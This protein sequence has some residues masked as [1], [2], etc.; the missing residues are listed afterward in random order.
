MA[1]GV[2]YRASFVH[3]VLQAITG[4]CR[5]GAFIIRYNLPLASSAA[6]LADLQKNCSKLSASERAELATEVTEAGFSA[7]DL[8][9][10]VA[11]LADGSGLAPARSAMQD[12]TSL[13][14]MFLEEEW[15][16][17]MDGNKGRAYK[18]E[19]VLNRAVQLGGRSVS[20]PAKLEWARML[21]AVFADDCMDEEALLQ[22]IRQD[23]KR[24]AR[25]AAKPQVP[26]KDLPKSFDELPDFYKEIFNGKRPVPCKVRWTSSLARM[27]KTKAAAVPTLRIGPSASEVG[28]GQIQ[29]FAQVLMKGMEA[30]HVAQERMADRQDKF[31]AAFFGGPNALSLAQGVQDAAAKK[32]QL[33]LC[34]DAAEAPRR[35]GPA[36]VEES[37]KAAASIRK[38][39]AGEDANAAAPGMHALQ[40]AQDEPAAGRALEDTSPLKRKPSAAANDTSEFLDMLESRDVAKKARKAKGAGKG[41]DADAAALPPKK[42]LKRAKAGKAPKVKVPMKAS[43]APKSAAPKSAKKPSFSVERSRSQIQCRENSGKP[44]ANWAIKYGAGTGLTEAAAKAKASKWLRTAL[45][46]AGYS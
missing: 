23:F 22:E 43:P 2:N 15:A 46:K 7:V 1:P 3:R 9:R 45:Q 29:A 5:I 39:R 8:Q 19:L 27:R 12:F 14:D 17:L 33:A 20:E 37:E 38:P 11:K 28:G 18:K 42:K 32:R 36:I 30:M 13:P 16:A 4:V 6:L 34:D 24:L 31:M 25:K 21:K 40:D 35:G 26:M 10:I 41:A 44:G